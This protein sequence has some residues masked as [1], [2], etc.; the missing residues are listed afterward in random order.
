MS[1]YYDREIEEK[2]QYVQALKE[3]SSA[4]KSRLLEF[5][6]EF[7]DAPDWFSK[8]LFMALMQLGGWIHLL[9]FIYTYGRPFDADII[10]FTLMKYLR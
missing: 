8:S 9:S 7:K 4:F 6:E 2:A 3:K 5:L 1:T 10:N